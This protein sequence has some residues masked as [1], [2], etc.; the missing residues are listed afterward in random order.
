MARHS[1][2][3]L[4]AGLLTIAL[5]TALAAAPA[6]PACAQE[7]TP[8]LDAAHVVTA[9]GDHLYRLEVAS[10]PADKERGLM[11]RRYMP[12][13]RGMLFTFAKPR[14]VQFW[15]HDTYIPLDMLFVGAD[16]RIVSI[17]RDAQPMSDAIVSSGVETAAVIEINAG[18]AQAIGAAV[19]D[20]VTDE[21][22]FKR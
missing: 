11:F 2:I 14:V 6:V 19:G 5:A 7:A 15:M 8:A 16:G 17:A 12:A 20:R 22:A 1:A 18:Q 21:V 9:S 10:T 13:D 4:T 3:R